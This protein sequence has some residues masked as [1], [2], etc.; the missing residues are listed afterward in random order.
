MDILLEVDRKVRGLMSFISEA[1]E[2]DET[3]LRIRLENSRKYSFDEI[4]NEIE[5]LLKIYS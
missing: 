1:L 5:R 2:L 4:K 3:K